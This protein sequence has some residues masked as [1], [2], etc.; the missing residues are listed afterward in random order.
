MPRSPLISS[1]SATFCYKLVIQPV[2]ALETQSALMNNRRHRPLMECPQLYNLGSALQS[3]QELGKRFVP[4]FSHT[5]VTGFIG[6]Q[7]VTEQRRLVVR[8]SRERGV[9]V[10]ED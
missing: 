9:H 7:V 4:Y 2:F 3:A 1:L 6:M 8:V 10:H 5:R